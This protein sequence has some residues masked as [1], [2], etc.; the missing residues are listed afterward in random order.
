MSTEIK[1]RRGS[2]IYFSTTNPVLSDGEPAL[3]IDTGKI[4]YGDG[5][6]AWNSLTYFSLPAANVSGLSEVASAAAPVQSVN[7]QTDDVFLT[8]DNIPKSDF[9][10]WSINSLNFDSAA[11]GRPFPVFAAGKFYCFADGTIFASADG[12][13]W[14]SAAAPVMG[15]GTN[16]YV[17]YGNGIFVLISLTQGG[18]FSNL[19]TSPDGIT[20]TQRPVP[21]GLVFSTWPFSYA[22]QGRG[23]PVNFVNDRFVLLSF[24]GNNAAKSAVSTDGLNW[25]VSSGFLPTIAGGWWSGLA[26]GAGLYVAVATNSDTKYATSPDGLNWTERNSL[27]TILTGPAGLQNIAFGNDCFVVTNTQ[28]QARI[29]RSVDGINWT[30]IVPQSEFDGVISVR[31]VDNYFVFFGNYGRVFTS[32]DA[33]TFAQKTSIPGANT[34]F[35]RS[36]HG[37][38]TL[39]ISNGQGSGVAVSDDKIITVARDIVF[40]SFGTGANRF[41]Q[42]NDS[43]LSDARNPLATASSTAHGNS[44]SS[45][46]LSAT[47]AV[48]TCSLST[49]CTFAMPTASASDFVLILTQTGSFT[50]T[51]TGVRW[52]GNAAPTITTGANKI[53][54]IRFVSN[55]TNWYG[56]ITQ[57]YN[58]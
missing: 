25:T 49:N 14:T 35:I 9:D 38:G 10:N 24:D 47:S 20:W 31:Y 51:F 32:K 45:R 37:N 22:A 17:A 3:E 43:R 39:L 56:Q 53:D 2:A 34:S 18:S 46:T 12:R 29:G 1:I 15:R 42:G 5:T 21:S 50:A 36:A 28:G 13:N 58:V 19:H 11:G 8:I 54:I 57:N 27:P 4:K 55:G 30:L 48:Q 26:Y 44:G 41:C 7:S 16:F 52:P 6:T 40:N 23:S 33:T